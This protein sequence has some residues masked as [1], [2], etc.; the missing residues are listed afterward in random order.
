MNNQ[1]KLKALILPSFGF[2]IFWAT[3]NVFEYIILNYQGQ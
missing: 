3:W 1:E 2:F